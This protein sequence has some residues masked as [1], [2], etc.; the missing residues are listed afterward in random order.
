MYLHLILG[1]HNIALHIFICLI[2]NVK[3]LINVYILCK[4]SHAGVEKIVLL[5]AFFKKW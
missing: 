5:Y 1:I 3:C 4:K 2:I